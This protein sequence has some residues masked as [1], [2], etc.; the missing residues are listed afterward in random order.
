MRQLWAKYQNQCLLVIVRER[1]A[2]GMN[3]PGIRWYALHVKTHREQFVATCLRDI[4][5]EEFVPIH[6]RICSLHKQS[7]LQKE[8]ALFPG[9]LFCKLDWLC[10]PKV[11]AIPGVIRVVGLGQH[12]TPLDDEEIAAIRTVTLSACKLELWPYSTGSIVVIQRGP[13]RGVKGFVSGRVK[14]RFIVTVPLLQRAVAI[15]IDQEWIRQ[16][17]RTSFSPASSAA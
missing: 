5:Q 2:M 11:S 16:D 6:A 17:S 7:H 4:G 3:N 1:L 12:P 9:Y 14:E 13:L 15:T 10:G 8:Q